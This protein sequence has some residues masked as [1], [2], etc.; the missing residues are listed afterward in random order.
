[1]GFKRF[2]TIL[3]ITVGIAALAFVIALF[4]NEP[5]QPGTA[6]YQGPGAAIFA[7]NCARCHGADGS[8][9]IGPQLADRVTKVFPDPAAQIAVV[10][11]GRGGMPAFGGDLTKA[12]I[13]QVVDFTRKGLG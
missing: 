13:A 12:Q 9:G 2:V 5:S 1:V 3:E 4:V 7:A 11:H 6:S 10:T 8:G